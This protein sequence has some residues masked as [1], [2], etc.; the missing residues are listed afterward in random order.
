[1]EPDVEMPQPSLAGAAGATRTVRPR[2]AW[3][4]GHVEGLP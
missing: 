2:S 3:A 1:M 4:A